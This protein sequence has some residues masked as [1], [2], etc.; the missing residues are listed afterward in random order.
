MSKQTLQ[1][2]WPLNLTSIF[3]AN[4]PPI[5]LQCILCCKISNILLNLIVL[6]VCKNPGGRQYKPKS[7]LKQAAARGP[8][9]ALEGE[10]WPYP[11]LHPAVPTRTP[12]TSPSPP[13]AVTGTLPG[14]RGPSSVL[15]EN[16]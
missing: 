9:P 3:V 16:C 15:L 1:Q 10:G 5:S 7:G 4:E 6:N 14:P 12:Q 11:S 8:E 13:A 2:L